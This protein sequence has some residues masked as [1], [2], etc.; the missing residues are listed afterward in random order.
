MKKLLYFFLLS[1][2]VALVFSCAKDEDSFVNS[3]S[4]IEIRN[5]GNGN[6]VPICHQLGNGESETIYVNENALQA[7]LNHGDY[8]GECV[9]TSQVHIELDGTATVPA[10]LAGFYEKASDCI[11]EEGGAA[12]GN[13]DHSVC[14][15]KT[16]GSDWRIWNTGCGWEIGQVEFNGYDYQW[17]RYARYYSGQCSSIPPEGLT[18]EALTTTTFYNGF[19][20]LLSGI[21][22]TLSE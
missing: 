13:V 10:E 14:F 5:P 17:K 22:S 21:T 3:N 2:T 4:K 16:D 1:C 7:H 8:E 20:N 15:R 19:G 6:T 11:Q 9:T 18:T 12:F